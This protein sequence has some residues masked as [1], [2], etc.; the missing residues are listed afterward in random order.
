MNQHLFLKKTPFMRFLFIFILGIFFTYSFFDLSSQSVS[1]LFAFILFI[2]IVLVVLSYRN[3]WQLADFV[4]LVLIFGT[5]VMTT[6]LSMPD[7]HISFDE[8]K[9]YS[10]KVCDNPQLKNKS[11]LLPA[12]VFLPESSSRLKKYRINIYTAKDSILAR[13]FLVGREIYFKG[14]IERI[15]NYGNPGEFDYVKFMASKGIFF[16]VWVKDSDIVFSDFDSSR[17]RFILLLNK[18]R[19]SVLTQIE[20]Y[21][22]N[23]DSKALVLAFVTGDRTLISDEMRDAYVHAGVVHILSVSGLHIGI[24]FMV[25]NFLLKSF[26]QNQKLKIIKTLLIILVVWFY[27]LIS[28]LSSSVTRSAVMFTLISIG[29]TFRRDISFY[30]IMAA[31][32]FIM[33]L[34]NPLQLF[35]IGFQLSYLAVLG[36]VYFQP[37]LSLLFCFSSKIGN[38][39]YQL[40]IVSFAAQLATFPLIVFY[41]NQFSVYFWLANLFVIPLTF[42]LMVLIVVFMITSFIP[43][44]GNLL[45]ILNSAVAWILNKIVL[46]VDNLPGSVLDGIYVSNGMVILIFG[47]I[48]AIA[49]WL[50]YKKSK[51]LI[52][53]L[54]ICGLM[55]LIS[56]VE[57]KKLSTENALIFF[58]TPGQSTF[59]VFSNSSK[60]YIFSSANEDNSLQSVRSVC[61][62]YWKRINNKNEPTVVS[63]DSV[64]TCFSGKKDSYTEN[65][66]LR[67]NNKTKVL[68]YNHFV[69]ILPDS[70]FGVDEVVLVSGNFPPPTKSVQAKFVVLSSEMNYYFTSQWEK[71]LLENKIQY[72]TIRQDG[73]YVIKL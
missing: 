17:V 5:S 49:I 10:A 48:V 31:S 18:I 23:N 58:N 69:H 61:K 57:S 53:G 60:N 44:F 46:L 22:K 71:Y 11:L 45:G 7:S 1:L 9:V 27:A 50:E 40:L 62:N 19:K 67:F 4:F 72:H 47:L 56:I 25:F 32:A 28:G 12:T 21:I 51:A 35:D 41:F 68:V 34:F 6:S 38:Y 33:L 64:S 24:I 37:R 36:I 16:Q 65:A 52:L 3:K 15:K 26:N 63:L 43:L 8:D 2:L 66:I 73:A 55:L 59:G 29:Q 70:A 13:K 20:K 42:V 14:K 39:I 30:N 54:A